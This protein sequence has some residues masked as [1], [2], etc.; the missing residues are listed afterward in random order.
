[1]VGQGTFL[2]EL[3]RL[4]FITGWQQESLERAQALKS[5]MLVKATVA[6]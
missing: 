3:S 4:Q 6:Q 2:C 5:A 1:M